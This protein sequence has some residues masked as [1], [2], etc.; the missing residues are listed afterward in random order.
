MWAVRSFQSP[1]IANQKKNEKQKRKKNRGI[2]PASPSRHISCVLPPP[3]LFLSPPAPPPPPVQPS[4]S[5]ATPS[6]RL[7]GELLLCSSLLFL[8]SLMLPPIGSVLVL[9]PLPVHANVPAAAHAI[10]WLAA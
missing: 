8:F 9:V 7:L 4:S 1:Y 3:P 6:A 5:F 10:A 2:A